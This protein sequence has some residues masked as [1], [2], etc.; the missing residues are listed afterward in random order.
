MKHK[1]K[2]WFRCGHET[3]SLCDALY[4]FSLYFALIWWPT[5]GRR[6]M[7]VEPWSH[8]TIFYF[9]SYRWWMCCY[10]IH[11]WETDSSFSFHVFYCGCKMEFCSAKKRRDK[12]QCQ[13]Q[14]SSMLWWLQSNW[15]Y[16]SK[17]F[18][19]YSQWKYHHNMW[20]LS[21]RWRKG[22]WFWKLFVIMI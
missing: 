8:L 1:E 14:Q 12:Q 16:M 10:P 4:L 19:R 22:T 20:F 15:R 2:F 6:V 21:T 11:W 7:S 9:H 3:F 5:M 13:Y 18:G 17:W